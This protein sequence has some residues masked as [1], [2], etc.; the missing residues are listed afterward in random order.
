MTLANQ[1]QQLASLGDA[2]GASSVTHIPVRYVL[3]RN[4][5]AQI[6]N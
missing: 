5:L 1:V 2:M 6:I 4:R 3:N